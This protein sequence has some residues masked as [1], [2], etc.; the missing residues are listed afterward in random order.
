MNYGQVVFF[1]RHESAEIWGFR[2][3]NTLGL[4]SQKFIARTGV[5]GLIVVDLK[6]FNRVQA[7]QASIIC[8]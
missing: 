6:R 2:Y 4:G 5:F 3:G 1:I 7:R 8:T